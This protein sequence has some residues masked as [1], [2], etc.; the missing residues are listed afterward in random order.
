MNQNKII[1]LFEKIYK[2]NRI[3]FL[4]D[5]E[6][7]LKNNKKTFIVTANPEAFMLAEKSEKYMEILLDK[8]TII[9]PDGIG[10][11]KAG[12]ILNYDINE[13]IPG[14]DIAEKLL[15][16]ANEYNKSIYLFG[17]KQ[18]VIDKMTSLI[19][20]KYPKITI[21]GA[22]NGYEKDKD[23]VF[24]DIINKEADIVLVALGMPLQE[25]LIYKNLSKFKK[26]I[27]VGIGGSFDVLSGTKKRAPE[28]FIKLN[29]EWLYR[30]I[31]EPARIQRFYNNN[32]KFILR[33]FELRNE[34]K[35]DKN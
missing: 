33:I 21:I 32:I 30:I 13:R 7:K 16:L 29:L 34:I 35:K 25:E 28:L 9:V 18:E 2:K 11:V 5:L 1:I 19:K 24:Q 4:D 23:K 12:R 27:F 17:A 3:N 8:N 10:L 6:K 15:E 22:K 14:I 31:K 20:N 26:G